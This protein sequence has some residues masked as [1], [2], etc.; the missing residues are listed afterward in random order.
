MKWVLITLLLLLSVLWVPSLRAAAPEEREALV[1]VSNVWDG[2][3]YRTTFDPPVAGTLYCLAGQ[4]MVL[5]LT[6]TL[7]YYWP[8]T[9][10][11]EAD[12]LTRD[13]TVA[14]I[15]EVWQRSSRLATLRQEE[16]V[17]QSPAGN[18]DAQTILYTGAAARRKFAEYQAGQ[19][20]YRAAL[21]V[22]SATQGKQPAGQSVLAPPQP[23]PLATTNLTRGFVLNLPVGTYTLRLI[24][25]SGTVVPSSERELVV[26]APRRRGVSYQVIPEARWTAPELSPTDLHVIYTS[27]AQ[28]IYLAPYRAIEVPVREYSG[29]RDPQDRSGWRGG[30]RWVLTQPLRDQPLRIRGRHDVSQVPY[31]LYEVVQL[32][33]PSL[34]YRVVE[35]RQGKGPSFGGYRLALGP[36]FGQTQIILGDD[37][38]SARQI[39]QIPTE[40]NPWG[41]RGAAVAL[42]T[43][44]VVSTLWRRFRLPG[45]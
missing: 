21:A 43:L 4:P 9:R 30:W 45:A 42:A 2:N 12:W 17:I 34:G 20:Q 13:E 7:V 16:Y 38:E 10:R 40:R 14:G 28:T 32:P 41:L 1:W 27:G 22:V 37:L 44:G 19:D 11:Y 8:L 29:L 33:G 31:R 18:F 26:F 23:P 25:P 15:L 39:R 3:V 6:R 35:A 24:A 36:G 5:R